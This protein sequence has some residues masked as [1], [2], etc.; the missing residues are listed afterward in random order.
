MHVAPFL[1]GFEAHSSVLLQTNKKQFQ[2]SICVLL[3][4]SS[5]APSHVYIL[6]TVECTFS[7]SDRWRGVALSRVLLFYI[8]LYCVLLFCIVLYCIILCFVLL[9]CTVLC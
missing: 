5:E 1:Q 4:L 7:T 8:V 9:F 3:T 2:Y 6:Y